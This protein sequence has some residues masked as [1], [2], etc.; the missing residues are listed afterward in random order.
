MESSK[1]K[2]SAVK[3]LTPLKRWAKDCHSASI[4]L[5]NARIGTRVAR[6]FCPGVGSQHSWVVVGDDCYDSTALIIDATLWSYIPEMKGIFVGTVAEWG[7]IPHGNGSIWDWGRPVAGN[8]ARIRLTPKFK[9]SNAAKQF[10]LMVEPLDYIGWARL[11]S[12]PAR[13]WP[14]GEIFAAMDDTKQLSALVPI[15]MLGM[16]TDRNPSGLYLPTE[17]KVK[18]A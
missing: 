3:A 4:A 10:L 2:A 11:S 12:A 14:A 13:G 16:L 18:A 5:V 6:G 1:L 7:H 9:L 15:D 8:S 17:K